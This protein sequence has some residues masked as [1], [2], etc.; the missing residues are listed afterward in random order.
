MPHFSRRP[1]DLRS[2]K[3]RANTDITTS[4]RSPWYWCRCNSRCMVEE[5]IDSKDIDDENRQETTGGNRET[6]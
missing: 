5:N 6:D 1:R 3:R 4:V 2:R